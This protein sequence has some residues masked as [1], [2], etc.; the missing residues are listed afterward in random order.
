MALTRQQIID[1][2]L[3]EWRQCASTIRGLTP[4]QWQAVGL[5]DTANVYR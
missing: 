5:D 2:T 1:G 3:D 4:E